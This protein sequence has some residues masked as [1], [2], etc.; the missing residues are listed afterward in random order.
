M[1]VVREIDNPS[2]CEVYDQHSGNVTCA[3]F[4]PSGNYVASGD[5][6]G[7]IRVW[8]YDHPEKLLKKEIPAFPMEVTGVAWGPESK[9]LA[10]G[11]GGGNKV[12]KAFMAMTG[13]SLG[14]DMV[15]L[16]KRVLSVDYKPSRPYRIVACGED[17]KAAFYEGPPF[18]FKC[19]NRDHTNFANCVRYAPDGGTYATVSS[20]RKVVL[21]DGKTGEKKGELTGHGGGVYGC[22]WSPDGAKL[23][24]A[25]A[26]KTVKVWDVAS[27]ACE[28]TLACVAPGTKPEVGDM[29]TAVLWP[30][31]DL[32]LSVS[33][34]GAI[35]YLDPSK[36]DAGPVR[37]VQGHQST[38]ASLSAA[39]GGGAIATGAVL[40]DVCVWDPASGMA[41]H[42]VGGKGHRSQAVGVAISAGGALH[43]VGWD[44]VVKRAAAQDGADGGFAYG[45]G[46]GAALGGQPRGLA[47]CAGDEGFA[48]AV[49]QHALV[50]IRDGAKVGEVACAWEPTCVAVA[51]DGSEVAVGGADGKVHLFAV[52]GDAATAKGEYGGWGSGAKVTAAAYSPD[53]A[54]F[55]GGDSQKN[56]V[57]ID[58]AS[59]DRK[60]PGFWCYHSSR[61]NGLAFSANSQFVASAGLD[62]HIY[63]W[64]TKKGMKRH[65]IKFAHKHG[66]NCVAWTGDD[67]LVSAGADGCIKTWKVTLP[68][69]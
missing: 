30:R 24:T 4:S 62:S 46:G 19:T 33:L 20:D 66:A 69:V 40:G 55:I 15:G 7:K 36:G 27:M 34:N 23:A 26:D 63:V 38:I 2:Q 45:A 5:S 47:G 28:A 60:W 43:S 53:G 18:K 6:K 49:T 58:R 61:I 25:S 8:A 41:G 65:Q 3:A 64:N 12:V 29:Q 21:Y 56:L 32:V 35:N 59:G 13:S 17:F 39:P 44:D 57:L 42:R 54:W 67:E 10:A 22:A 48:A 31:P 14:N 9:R 50:L 51:A 52:A 11:G 1:V 68:G 16:T 37:V